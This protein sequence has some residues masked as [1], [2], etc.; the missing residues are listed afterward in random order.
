M[1]VSMAVAC[2][3]MS[4][5]VIIPYYNESKTIIDT[6]ESLELQT[7]QPE[8]IILVDSGSTDNSKDIIDKWIN[9]HDPKKYNNIYSGRMSPSTSINLGIKKSKENIIAYIDC[10]LII[11]NN[12]LELSENKLF[13]NNADIVSTTIYTEGKNYIDKCFIS[14]T[15]GYKNNTPCL[16]GSLIKRVVFNQVGYFLE[17]VRASYDTDFIHKVK[18][19]NLNREINRN[20]QL[21]YMG[22]NYTNNFLNGTKKVYLYSLSGWNAVNDKKPFMYTLLLII[23]LFSFV[24]NIISIITA[25]LIFYILSRIIFIPFAKSNYNYK[26]LNP[27][28]FPGLLIAGVIID[29][30]RTSAYI[31][32][33]FI[34]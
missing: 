27:L 3:H 34:N 21:E 22:I 1:M 12:W 28:N 6:L 2:P 31:V 33:S 18:A 20:I 10:G 11:P 14:Q 32:S 17:N 13:A 19:K 9:T 4:I 7:R 15:Y 8:R 23:F 26:V 29:V 30:S 24:L 5:V 25:F 16:P